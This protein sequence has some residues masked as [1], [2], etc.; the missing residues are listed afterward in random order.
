[1]S[2]EEDAWEVLRFLYDRVKSIR[3]L[4]EE[5]KVSKSSIR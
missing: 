5:L 2:S 4:A 3:E 1:V